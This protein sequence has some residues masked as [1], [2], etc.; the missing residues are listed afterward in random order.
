[1]A[2]LKL[3]PK[4]EQINQLLHCA[5]ISPDHL[6]QLVS[7][8]D[9]LSD[10][11][12]LADELLREFQNYIS[13]E[14]SEVLLEQVLSLSMLVRQSDSKPLEITRALRSSIGAEDRA[15][16]DSVATHFQALLESTA[17][18]LVT[19][20]MELSLDYANL[21]RNARILTDL[22]PLFDEL[23]DQ[24]VGGVVTHTLRIDYYGDGGSHELSLAMDISDIEGLRNQCERS[25]TKARTIRDQFV[26]NMKKPCLISGETEGKGE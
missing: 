14:E 22:R 15:K 8:L 13:S 24:V 18:R 2:T 12:L 16:W 4:P 5:E 9:Q 23:G 26:Q 7:H 6:A 17:V 20:A 21:L 11:P 3:K 25:I 19:K 1:M 10:P